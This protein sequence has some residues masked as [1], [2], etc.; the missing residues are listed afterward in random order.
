MQEQMSQKLCKYLWKKI[1]VLKKIK[2]MKS[3]FLN[4]KTHDLENIEKEENQEMNYFERANT[5]QS[6]TQCARAQE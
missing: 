1:Y 3:V 6:Y 4:R 2:F 5:L